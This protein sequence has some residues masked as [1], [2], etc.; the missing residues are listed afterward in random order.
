MIK[1][2]RK[3]TER[4][5]SL[6]E[7][8][9]SAMLLVILLS[10]LLDLGRVYFTYVALE[11]A[12]GEAALYLSLNPSC[13][14]DNGNPDCSDPN[15][16]WWRARHA[17]GGTFE[18]LLDWDNPNPANRPQIVPDL[19]TANAVGGKVFVTIKY[20]F[21]LVTPLIRNMASGGKI[22]LQVEARQTIVSE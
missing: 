1:T 10:G 4:G 14:V 2:T 6:V 18:G 17:T 13:K 5:Q 22:P 8:S 15:N 9:L 20:D 16:A 7:F 11:D 12:A 19:P 3:H 21:P